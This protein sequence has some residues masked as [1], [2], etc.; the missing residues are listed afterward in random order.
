MTLVS[1]PAVKGYR[2][3]LN[4]VFSL[5]G[6]DSASNL[7]VSQSQMFHSFEKCCPPCEVRPPD[8]NLLLVLR[9]LS[10]PPFEPLKPASDKHL[11]WRTSF[12][13]AF[14]LAKRVNELY[15]LSFC[16]SN[17]LGWRSCTFTF[18]PDFV[19]KTQNPVVPNPLFDEFTIPSL[20]DFVDGDRD[21]F[22]LCPI[23]ALCKY[24]SRSEQ[25]HPDIK[26]LFLSTGTVE[27]RLFG[28]HGALLLLDNQICRIIGY[29]FPLDINLIRNCE[30]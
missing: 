15:S 8:W 12:L 6:V 2:A 29:L 26:S 28:Y 18:L 1:V 21:E 4:R 19:T 17:F 20:D 7:V 24:L 13:L 10:R 30:I 27:F 5:T 11:T 22:L 16:V 3:A 14:A 25:Y 9:C 23:R